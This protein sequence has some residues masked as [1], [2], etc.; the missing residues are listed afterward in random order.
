MDC[1]WLSPIWGKGSP[2]CYCPIPL[3]DNTAHRQALPFVERL[4]GDTLID[5]CD[6][7]EQFLSTK[8]MLATGYKDGGEFLPALE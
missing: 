5:F 7:G 3:L 8:A 2:L 6:I 1:M 4:F